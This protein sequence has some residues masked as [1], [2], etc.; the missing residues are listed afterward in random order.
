MSDKHATA[1]SPGHGHGQGH[2]QAQGH[3]RDVDHG[4]SPIT[5]TFITIWLVLAFLT[6]IE[7][8]VPTVYSSEWNRH[9]K[10]LLLVVLAVGKASL[11]GAYFMHLKWEAAWIRWIA[12]MPV[13]MGFAAVILMCEEAFRGR[14]M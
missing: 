1:P 9:T 10:M 5:S 6:V 7:V 12:L 8:F 13:Y 11:V 3:V 14:V 2:G 4:D